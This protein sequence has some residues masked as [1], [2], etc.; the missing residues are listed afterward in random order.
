MVLVL[1]LKI[2]Q[3]R[4]DLHK[5]NIFTV[6]SFLEEL[7]KYMGLNEHDSE[8]QGLLFDA[9]KDSTLF[10]LMLEEKR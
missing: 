4:I 5:S 8:L 3:V 2:K 10:N 7:V 9:D 6:I 1:L